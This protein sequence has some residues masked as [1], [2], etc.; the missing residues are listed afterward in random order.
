MTTRLFSIIDDMVAAIG[1][2][3]TLTGHV[4]A[5]RV[6]PLDIGQLPAICIMPRRTQ[7]NALSGEVQGRDGTILVIVRTA[8]NE[9]GRAAH[10]L[11]AL[12]QQALMQYAPLND[13]S[14]QIDLGTET[15][16]Y[17]DSEQS[18]CD[19]QAEY[20]VAFDHDRDSLL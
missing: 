16:R 2:V 19:L 9:P 20:E 11:L 12:A 7:P 6:L 15:F 17:I 18:M 8:G 5:E 3:P 4:S 13:G 14:V 10:G 1:A